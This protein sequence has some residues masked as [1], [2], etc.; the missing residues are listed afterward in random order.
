MS[1]LLL[2]EIFNVLFNKGKPSM[3]KI[4]KRNVFYIFKKYDLHEE[5]GKL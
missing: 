2:V 3:G 4:K 1:L 5:V